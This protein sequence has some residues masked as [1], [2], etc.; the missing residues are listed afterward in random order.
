MTLWNTLTASRG[1]P[2][3]QTVAHRTGHADFRHLALEQNLTAS[4]V[5]LF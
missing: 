4:G 5:T 2:L 3:A 1:V